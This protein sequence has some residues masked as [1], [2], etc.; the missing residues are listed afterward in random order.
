MRKYFLAIPIIFISILSFAQS[1]FNNASESDPKAKKILDG[2]KKE[3]NSYKSMEVTFEL[4]IEL[5]GNAKELQKGRLIKSGKKFMASLTDQDVYC[6]G[7]TIWL[8]LKSN[9]EVQINNYEEGKSD[10]M[11]MSPTEMIKLYEGGKY[12]YAITGTAIENGINVTLIEFKPLDKKSEYSKM[13]LSVDTKKNKAVS[14]KVFSKDGSKYTLIV[15]NL[16][17]NKSYTSDVFVFN[18]KK[19]PGVR[20]EDLRID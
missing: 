13:R 18:A 10:Q 19:N 3:Y 7:K 8:H 6:D 17:P 9:K 1:Q 15:K 12:A 14:M 5:P 4:E 16:L 2:L 20:I 11:M